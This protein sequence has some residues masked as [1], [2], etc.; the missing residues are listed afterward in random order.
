MNPSLTDPQQ[1]KDWIKAQAVL[2]GFSDMGVSNGDTAAQLPYLEK[3]ISEQRNG[4]MDFLERNQHNRGNATMLV[5]GATTVLSF[6]MPYLTE[7]PTNYDNQ[8]ANIGIIARYALGRD[9]HKTLRQ[10]LKQLALLIEAQ[11]G[12][13]VWRPFSDSAPI[14]EKSLAEQSGLGWTGKHTL[15]VHPKQG[16]FFV[17]A[18]LVTNLNLPLDSP[19]IGN[20]CGSCTACIDVCP[21]Q[22][23][24]APYQ[25]DA[26]R[27]I[28]YLTIEYKGVIDEALRPLIGNRVFGCD[29]CQLVCPWNKFAKKTTLPDFMRREALADTDLLQLWQWTAAYF[30]TAT[31]GSPL[32]RTGYAAFMRNVAIALGNSHY[33]QHTIAALQQRLGSINSMV[34]THIHWAITQL[35]GRSP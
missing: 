29:D 20:H 18:E 7:A 9:Y 25:L 23:I 10:R 19:N 33:Q 15:L 2:L 12:P 31:Q 24:I 34:D 16:S 14:F 17:L 5:E 26:R 27:C 11:V 35:Q 6:K 28:A 21:T 3:Y 1:L 4:S 30:D 13:F 32:R 8:Q 22:A